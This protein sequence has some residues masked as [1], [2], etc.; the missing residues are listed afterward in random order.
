MDAGATLYSRLLPWLYL[1]GF[2]RL[3]GIDLR[4]EE[5]VV[6]KPIRYE[7][8]DLT[9]TTFDDASFD[10]VACLSVIEHGVPR[11]GYLREAS[12]LL[13]PGGLLITSTD[14]WCE[15]LD[16]GGHEAY[17]VEAKVFT[18]DELVSWVEAAPAH[19]F[20]ITSPLDLRCEERVVHW[21]RVGLDFTFANF[22]LEKVG[23][24]A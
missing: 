16:A 17:G 2:R 14:F 13:K 4:F 5:P 11:D 6:L 15:P 19:G 12:R 18:P 8:M 7:R 21:E 20:R 24:E 22:V 23:E 9:A 10:A 3:H 1:Y